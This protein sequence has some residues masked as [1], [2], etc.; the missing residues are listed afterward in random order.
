MQGGTIAVGFAGNPNEPTAVRGG[1]MFEFLFGIDAQL[2]RE[3]RRERFEVVFFNPSNE[4]GNR[5]GPKAVKHLLDEMARR[6]GRIPGQFATVEQRQAL[7]DEMIQQKVALQQARKEGLDRDPEYRAT[8]ERMLTTQ[9]LR[10]HLD[11]ELEKIEVTPA[12]VAAFYEAH[13]DEFLTPERI[14]A[15][16]IFLAVS[17]KADAAQVEKTRQRLLAAR[18]EAAKLPPETRNFGEIAKRYSEDAATRYVGGELGWIYESQAESYRWGADLVHSYFFYEGSLA[19]F[20]AQQLLGLPRGIT[21]YADHLLADYRLKLVAQQLAVADL[22][23][24]TSE[25]AR[26]ELVDLA[27]ACAPRTIVKPNAVDGHYFDRA[28]RVEPAPGEPFRLLSVARIDPKK[29]LQDLLAAAAEL[30][31]I[32]ES[33]AESYRWG[34]EL[35]QAAFALPAPGALSEVRR[36]EKGWYVLKLVEREEAAPTPIEKLAPG[37]RSRIQKERREAVRAAYFAQLLAGTPVTVDAAR[38]A[39]IAPLAPAESQATPPSLPRN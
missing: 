4:P 25:R 12:E 38:L 2:K 28:A 6:G 23:V 33:Q 10:T 36:H 35:V 18:D 31:W 14:R 26:R 20:V 5:L 8:I 29:G 3:G 7:L 37:I 27:P 19:A 32:Y 22:V 1:P 39:A 24:A 16:W 9:Y 30:G 21:C 34:A 15:A 11:P 13:R 17:A